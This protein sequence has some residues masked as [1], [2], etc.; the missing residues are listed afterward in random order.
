M[1]KRKKKRSKSPNTPLDRRKRHGNVLKSPFAALGDTVNW[2]SW[3]DQHLPNII[4]A[5]IL[6]GSL[7]REHYL[8]VFR[9]IATRAREHFKDNKD[10]SL[11][12]NFLATLDQETFDDIFS[13]INDDERALIVL[14]SLRLIESLPDAH[15]WRELLPEVEDHAFAWN[16]IARGVFEAMD[17]QSQQATDVRWLKLIFMAICGRIV[18][19]AGIDEFAE[20]LRLYPNHLNSQTK[21]NAGMVR[22]CDG[23]AL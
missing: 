20:E 7:E 8:S 14:Q 15:L 4:W 18:L 6:A 5:C 19:P 10:A 13:F 11:C 1:T 21:C 22:S 2:S 3:K 12:H 9:K 17:H 16:S 23:Q